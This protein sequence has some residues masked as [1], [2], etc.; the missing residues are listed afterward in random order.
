MTRVPAPSAL[1]SL[2]SRVVGFG[3]AFDDGE[4][5]PRAL[6]G[7][8]HVVAAAAEALENLHLIFFRDADAGVVDAESEPAVLFH[9]REER[10]AAARPA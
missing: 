7:A 9:L 3:E 8:R 2:T 1:S 4:T 5:E 6:V 10:D